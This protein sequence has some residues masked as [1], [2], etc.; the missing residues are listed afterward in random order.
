MSISSAPRAT[1]PAA[2]AALTALVWAPEGKPQT[3]VTASPS[4]TRT[5]SWLGDTHTEK[6]P[7]PAPW[8]TRA[9]TCAPVASGLRRV[10]SIM[11]AMSRRVVTGFLP[12]GPPRA[13]GAGG[14]R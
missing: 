8:A 1:A 4:G 10:W 14:A 13:D 11:R 6:T 2:S 12:T 3:V 7:S 5:G 9:A